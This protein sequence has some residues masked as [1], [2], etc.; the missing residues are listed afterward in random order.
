MRILYYIINLKDVYKI[1]NSV[2]F[3]YYNIIGFRENCTSEGLLIS[4]SR[5]TNMRSS[6]TV[7]DRA[8]I[9]VK[10]K[11][12]TTTSIALPWPK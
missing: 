7:V 4:F 6:S 12:T 5:I 2:Y 9:V 8:K 11:L 1:I 10:N 3:A